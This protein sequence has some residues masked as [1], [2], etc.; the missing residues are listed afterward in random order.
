MYQCV[1]TPS[2]NDPRSCDTIADDPIDVPSSFIG[3]VGYTKQMI[4]GTL[5]PEV[6]GAQPGSILYALEN[7]GTSSAS[8]APQSSGLICGMTQTQADF[9][10]NISFPYVALMLNVQMSKDQQ[11]MY[12]IELIPLLSQEFTLRFMKAALQTASMT[13]NKVN[14]VEPPPSIT[15]SILK[16]TRETNE[17]QNNMRSAIQTANE[18]YKLSELVRRSVPGAAGNFH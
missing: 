18:A 15:E 11:N 14:G 17:Y 12:S 10:S 1:G 9:I 6:N 7:C 5:T 8:P 2:Y 16:L 4:F 13:W 3:T